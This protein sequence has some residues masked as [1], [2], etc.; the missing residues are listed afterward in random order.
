M[1][2]LKLLI[3]F[4]CIVC[5]VSAQEGAKEYVSTIVDVTNN[6]PVKA[7]IS[8]QSLPYGNIV[9]IFH[10]STFVLSI[11]PE[12]K[13]AVHVEA[14]GY[15]AADMELNGAD[16]QL[17]K[18]IPLTPT[19]VGKLIRLES[20]IFAQ[21]KS[22]IPKVAYA[23]LDE[24]VNMLKNSTNMEVQLEGH[25]DFRGDSRQNMR[26]SERRVEATKN[27]LVSKGISKKRIKTK[28]F[29]GT[30]PLSRS[31]DPNTHRLNRRVEMRILKN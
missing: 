10:D 24:V 28:A 1:A 13:Y 30:Q 21:G 5:G 14:E 20:L 25:T 8:Y 16:E 31:N 7:R 18:M 23:E 29:G 19:G 22:D 3:V 15:L 6:N 4:C 27:Y 11:R 9:G 12:Q 2:K 26:L 17:K